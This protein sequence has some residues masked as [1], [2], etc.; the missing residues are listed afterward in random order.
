MLQTCCE[1]RLIQQK[2][3]KR[4]CFLSF[5]DPSNEWVLSTV[6]YFPAHHDDSRMAKPSPRYSKTTSLIELGKQ[7][8]QR[9]LELGLSQEE[10]ACRAEMDRSYIGGIERG[11]HNVSIVNLERLA[12]ALETTVTD[13]IT[14]AGF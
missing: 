10:F 7:V 13:L 14:K 12:K 5:R 2:A 6:A 9:R 3:F 11:E 4:A 8:R 1:E